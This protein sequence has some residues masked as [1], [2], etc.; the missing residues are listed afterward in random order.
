[1]K[2]PFRA[3]RHKLFN[4]GKLL[5]YLTYAVGEILLIIIGIMLALQLNNWNEDRKAEVEFELYLAQLKGDVELAI[6]EAR[7]RVSSSERRRAQTITVLEQLLAPEGQAVDSEA[8]ERALDG[9]GKFALRDFNLGFF[10][11]LLE[12]NLDAISRDRALTHEAMMMTREVKGLF[13]RMEV[14]QEHQELALATFAK[15]RALTHTLTPDIQ[16]RYD[17]ERMRASDEFIN[18]TQNM[19]Y[20]L[21]VTEEAYGGINQLLEDFLNLLEEYEI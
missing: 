12:G 8:F 6:R 17:L 1:M 19:A 10:G 3:I 18:A 5:R 16:L 4:E 2:S 7:F 11:Q 21:S 9:L 15:Y 20:F 14:N 13:T